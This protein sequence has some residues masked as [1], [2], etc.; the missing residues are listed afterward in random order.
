MQQFKKIIWGRSTPLNTFNRNCIA[1][2]LILLL[3][4]LIATLPALS[5]LNEG[6]ELSIT[7]ERQ[8]SMT[9]FSVQISAKSG[10]PSIV[11][12]HQVFE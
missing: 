4:S 9:V 8:I 10:F 6:M 1:F 7:S 3:N 12:R 5:I 11:Y 2:D